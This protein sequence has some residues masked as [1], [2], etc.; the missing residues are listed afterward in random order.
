[1]LRNR[2]KNF[3]DLLTISVKIQQFVTYLSVKECDYRFH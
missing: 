1:M 2:L 3:I